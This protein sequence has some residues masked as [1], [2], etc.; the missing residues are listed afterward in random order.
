[1]WSNTFV[2]N[3][4]LQMSKGCICLEGVNIKVK[5]DIGKHITH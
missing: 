2:G 1:M 3:N 4:T 5:D